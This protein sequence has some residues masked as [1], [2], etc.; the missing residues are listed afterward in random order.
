MCSQIH[1][2]YSYSFP[3]AGT[4]WM[5]GRTAASVWLRLMGGAEQVVDV[6]RRVMVYDLNAV[7]MSLEMVLPEVIRPGI[8]LLHAACSILQMMLLAFL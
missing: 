3:Q 8:V 2:E 7:H 4:I 5:C 6:W 1:R